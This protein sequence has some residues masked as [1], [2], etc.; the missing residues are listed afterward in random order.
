[1]NT[2]TITFFQVSEK[3]EEVVALGR[4]YH[5]RFRIITDFRGVIDN[6]IF[7]SKGDWLYIPL[8]E[9]D[10][11]IIPKTAFRRHAAV[12]KAGYPIA[13]VI[14]GHEVKVVPEMPVMPSITPSVLPFNPKPEIDWGNIAVVAGKGLLVGVMGIAM[15]SIYAL[16]GALRLI[17]P[18]YCIVLNDRQGTVV[19]LIRWNAEV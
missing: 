2:Q 16:I 12:E 6:P 17:D 11:T 9:E 14:I 1:M 18:S 19:E 3:A 10:K 15:I 4:R 5:W 8:T 7:N 13:Q